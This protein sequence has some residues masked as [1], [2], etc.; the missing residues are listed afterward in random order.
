[1]FLQKKRNEANETKMQ[2]NKGGRKIKK[3]WYLCRGV[4]I[5]NDFY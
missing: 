2:G 1:M 4:A 3:T 5:D